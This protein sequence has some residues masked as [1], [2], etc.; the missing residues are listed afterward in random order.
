MMNSR[1]T[2]RDFLSVSAGIAGAAAVGLPWRS[3]RAEAG[4]PGRPALGMQSYTLRKF[5]IDKAIAITA[6]LGLAH[7]EFY[8]GH[9][10]TNAPAAQIAAVKDK[11]AAAKLRISG[12]GV[13]HFSKDHEANRKLFDFAKAA[14]MRNIAADPSED[15]FGSLDKLVA[16][17]DIRIAIHNHGPGARYDKIADVLKAIKGHDPRVGAC[18][19]LGHYIRSAEDP[20]KAIVVLNDRLFGIHLKDFAEQKANSAGAIL[21][22]GHLDVVGVYKALQKV[23]FPADGAFSLEYE[24]NPADPLPDVKACIAAAREAEAK[25]A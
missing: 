8:T 13:M 23:S 17:Y 24:E 1:W 19:D 18:A 16:E 10:P 15:S 5:P 9:L 2:R 6:E 14:G 21:G 7:V 3:A 11:M 22:K 12:G 4:K 25:T 20:V